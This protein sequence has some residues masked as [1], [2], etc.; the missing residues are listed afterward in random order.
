MHRSKPC[1]TLFSKADHAR[2]GYI[3]RGC[4][5]ANRA[6][7]DSNLRS[8]ETA[9][10]AGCTAHSDGSYAPKAADCDA[11]M[12]EQLGSV[13]KQLDELPFRKDL[14]NQEKEYRASV[15]H[16]IAQRLAQDGPRI[17]Q[18]SPER[19]RQFMPFAAL[20][21]FDELNAELEREVAA[22]EE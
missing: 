1:T 7:S 11:V 19:G 13:M 5:A 22:R 16:Q 20:K 15:L 10:T 21:G 17:A 3:V 6:R 12:E 9:R 14:S 4:D 8:C 18:P 2:R